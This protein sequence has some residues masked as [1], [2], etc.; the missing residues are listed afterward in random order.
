LWAE[1]LIGC[2]RDRRYIEK[3]IL[4]IT[5]LLGAKKEIG[6]AVAT[7]EEVDS[8]RL[9][10]GGEKDHWDVVRGIQRGHRMV[11]L[12]EGDKRLEGTLFSEAFASKDSFAKIVQNQILKSSISEDGEH[13][14]LDRRSFSAILCSPGC[15][16]VSS[17][18]VYEFD[19]QD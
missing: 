3:K 1:I 9:L 19:M 18:S 12:K 14:A 4:I 7:R 8:E 16:F 15:Y 2:G 17:R 10:G 6:I 5:G 13:F 11:S